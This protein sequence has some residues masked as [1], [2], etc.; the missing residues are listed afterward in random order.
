MYSPTEL[1]A[2]L[3]SCGFEQITSIDSVRP[4]L[5]AN[6]IGRA[7]M[8]VFFRLAPFDRLSNTADCVAFKPNFP[9]IDEFR[10]LPSLVNKNG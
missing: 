6:R 5:G 2:L 8:E 4:L 7:V 3:Q 10:T 9:S 1:R